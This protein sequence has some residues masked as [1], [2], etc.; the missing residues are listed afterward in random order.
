MNKF[1]KHHDDPWF[2]EKYKDIGISGRE[3]FRLVYKPLLEKGEPCTFS[4]NIKKGKGHGSSDTPQHDDPREK[5]KNKKFVPPRFDIEGLFDFKYDDMFNSPPNKKFNK[6]NHIVFN[7]DY[8]YEE[9]KELYKRYVK[10]YDEWKSNGNLEK[11][12]DFVQRLSSYVWKNKLN[13]E[14]K[15]GGGVICAIAIMISNYIRTGK[16]NTNLEEINKLNIDELNTEMN[17]FCLF[18]LC[19]VIT[20]KHHWVE[21]YSNGRSVK[22]KPFVICYMR[23]RVTLRDYKSKNIIPS[24]HKEEDGSISFYLY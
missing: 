7:H 5:R 4:Q 2:I 14:N 8:Y 1:K 15:V 12:N 10:I 19:Q 13:T 3:E 21:L 23:H 11:V 16:L 9:D 24:F 6:L 20:T 18:L 17:K 22:D